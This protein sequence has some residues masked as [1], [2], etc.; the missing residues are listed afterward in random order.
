MTIAA[1][2]AKILI[3]EDNKMVR[4]IHKGMVENLGYI[5]DV[6]ENGEQALSMSTNGYDLIFMD[7]GLPGI[8]GIEA[9]SKIRSSEPS[10]KTNIVGLTA[11]DKE[12]V[13]KQCLS[14]GM[15]KVINKPATPDTLKLVITTYI[16]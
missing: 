7:L 2:K 4:E 16:H 3:V 1:E 15:D 14:A 10:K 11:Y 6:A 12:E 13:E 9:T 5:V 8:S